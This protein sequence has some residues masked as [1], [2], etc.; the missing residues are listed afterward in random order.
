[1]FRV[2]KKRWIS[3]D[4]KLRPVRP[5]TSEVRHSA[6]AGFNTA[7]DAGVHHHHLSDKQDFMSYRRTSLQ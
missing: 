7:G 4:M 5:Q 2:M 3:T 6:N 1:M